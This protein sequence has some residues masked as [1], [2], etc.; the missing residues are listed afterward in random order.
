MRG[1]ATSGASVR[2]GVG[3]WRGGRAE[4]NESQGN[5]WIDSEGEGIVWGGGKST[6]R[7]ESVT[8]LHSHTHTEQ[9]QPVNPASQ[10]WTGNEKQPGNLLSSSCQLGEWGVSLRI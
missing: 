3:L 4:Q 2:G 6:V 8:R 5:G 7:P 10:R 9:L 1:G